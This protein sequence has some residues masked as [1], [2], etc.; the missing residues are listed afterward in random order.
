M[1]LPFVFLILKIYKFSDDGD[2]TVT[3]AIESRVYHVSGSGLSTIGI[4]P[5]SD[6]GVQKSLSPS[7]FI[8]EKIEELREVACSRSYS[9]LSDRTRLVRQFVL[10]S[11]LLTIT[12]HYF[13]MC[14]L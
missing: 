12:L 9:S 5:P 11:M 13:H 14:R 6:L 10:M 2:T 7:L 8:V 4:Y 3:T 1:L